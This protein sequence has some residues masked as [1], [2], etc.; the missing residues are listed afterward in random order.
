MK[1]TGNPGDWEVRTLYLRADA[2]VPWLAEGDIEGHATQARFASGDL[3]YVR[4]IDPGECSGVLFWA[5]FHGA[6]S[7]HVDWLI[8][9]SWYI[10]TALLLAWSI[11]RQAGKPKCGEMRGQQGMKWGWN[12]E[13]KGGGVAGEARWEKPG[14]PGLLGAN[15]ET[16]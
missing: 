16:A 14:K 15:I 5:S 11:G 2:Q 7:C 12:S 8:I 13:Q 3:T 10:G 6:S 1:R 9:R 4:S